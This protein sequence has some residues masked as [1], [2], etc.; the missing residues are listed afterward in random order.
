MMAKYSI[1]NRRLLCIVS[2]YVLCSSLFVI[3]HAKD[4][5]KP[6]S[7]RENELD[8]TALPPE[9][10]EI[11]AGISDV[12]KDIPKAGV[13]RKSPNIKVAG[14]TQETT[15]KAAAGEDEPDLELQLY[16]P[17]ENESIV[18]NRLDQ[19]TEN[20]VTVT[21]EKTDDA[22]AIQ[23]EEEP[24]SQNDNTE[25]VEESDTSTGD[26]AADTPAGTDETEANQQ[27]DQTSESGG[28]E[29]INSSLEPPVTSLLTY[30]GITSWYNWV[31]S[32]R[33][34]ERIPGGPLSWPTI[35][36]RGISS[37]VSHYN[38]LGSFTGRDLADNEVI[39]S[40]SNT[41]PFR[42]EIIQA[43][44]DGAISSDVESINVFVHKLQAKKVADKISSM[45]RDDTIATVE[46]VAIATPLLSLRPLAAPI[47]DA[48]Q[49]LQDAANEA[50]DA[51]FAPL[52]VVP[53][54]VQAAADLFDAPFSTVVAVPQ[55]I[56]WI[57]LG[58]KSLYI[59][60]RK[61]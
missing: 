15:T 43:I 18:P 44:K 22:E 37:I 40:L 25:N 58:L 19:K 35:L 49:N 3:T 46:D 54:E 36:G 47:V 5:E 31:M 41:H 52:D 23:E 11:V 7:D 16:E 12:Q 26:A 39:N 32:M 59:L 57:N 27:E 56:K 30:D 10:A 6:S 48:V 17:E 8:I 51:L 60:L 42:E 55:Y 24:D 13:K 29:M 2:I 38:P 20:G 28:S 45:S 61:F 14:V 21:T 33:D 34:P 1:D 53:E 4:E 9:V 50:E